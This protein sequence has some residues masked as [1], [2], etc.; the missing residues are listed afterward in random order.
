VALA[1]TPGAGM[2]EGRMTRKERLKKNLDD[3]PNSAGVYLMKDENGDV[4]YVGKALNVRKRVRSYF[5]KRADSP[6]IE[7]LKTRIDSVEYIAT[8][9]EVEALLLEAN[10][11][12]TYYPR[13]NTLLK[14]DK[15]YP[16][17]KI[18]REPFPRIIVTREQKEKDG[19]YFGPYTDVRLLRQ[20]VSLINMIFPIRKCVTL[21][22]KPCLYYFLH[23]CLAPCSKRDVAE[24]YARYI[25][26]I[27]DFLKGNRK[28]F[29]EYLTLHMEEAARSFKYEEAALFK[30]QI[31]ALER[32]KLTRYRVNDPGASIALSGT[33]ELKKVLGLKKDPARIVCF[34]VSNCAGTN[35]VAARV[36]FFREVETKEYY[37]KYKIKTVHG[38]D[39]YAMMREALERMARGILEGREKFI[40]DLIMIDGGKGHLAAAS[41]VLKNAGLAAIPVIAIA[42]KLELVYTEG[43]SEPVPLIAGG[44]AHNLLRRIR[45]EAHRF[46]IS[47]H[48]QLRGKE[49]SISILDSVPGIGPKRKKILL[50]RFASIDMIRTASVDE[51]EKLPSFNHELAERICALFKPLKFGSGL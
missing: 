33:R 17:L 51:I 31:R 24:K 11:I 8:P 49:M 44:L 30:E 22:K 23:Q 35:A 1:I 50:E 21:P 19:D 29:I 18:T 36:S 6:K 7:V 41:S 28:S 3:L 13:Y 12:E 27:K 16:L 45:D 43:E 9:T 42:K 25:A 37:R 39:D 5:T 38:I 4:I 32:I 20:A 46:A 47:Y 48:R 10:L 2:S 26:E 15:T 40:P 34:D 14:D